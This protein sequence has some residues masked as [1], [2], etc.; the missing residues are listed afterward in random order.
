MLITGFVDTSSPHN[1]KNQRR[2][3]QQASA[4]APVIHRIIGRACRFHLCFENAVIVLS[5]FS[6]Q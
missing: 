5:R 1:A 2:K 3:L 4:P 6:G